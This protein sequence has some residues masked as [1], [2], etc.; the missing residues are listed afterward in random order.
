MKK[1]TLTGVYKKYFFNKQLQ[2]VILEK[3]D[4]V[5]VV[6][7]IDNFKMINDT[8]GHQTGDTVLKE[9]SGLIQQNIRKED[10]FARWGGEEFLLL[11][12]HTTLENAMKKIERLRRTLERHTFSDI[13]KMTASFGVAWK[14]ESDDLHSL[15]QRADKALYEAKKLGKN[16]VIFKKV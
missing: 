9:F 15:L 8:Y 1:D 6:I 16:K 11:L 5:V 13:G 4:A 10:I 12:Q 2:K 3:E 7:D 14:E